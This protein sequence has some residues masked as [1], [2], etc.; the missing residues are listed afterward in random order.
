[1]E[2][3]KN[4]DAPSWIAFSIVL[5]K[6]EISRKDV[7]YTQGKVNSILF[8]EIPKWVFEATS[9]DWKEFIDELLKDPKLPAWLVWN[10]DILEKV[11]DDE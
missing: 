10:I 7:G 8:K 2:L 3:L 11:L 6:L 4:K 9:H 1:L 5:F